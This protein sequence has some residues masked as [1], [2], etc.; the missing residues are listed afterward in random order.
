MSV[1]ARLVRGPIDTASLA[2]AA[3]RDG[4]ACLFVGVV[5]DLNRGSG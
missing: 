3:P 1:E 5:R 4:A 2:A